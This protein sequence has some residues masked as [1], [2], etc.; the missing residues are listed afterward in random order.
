MIL[1]SFRQTTIAAYCKCES[2]AIEVLP[3]TPSIPVVVQQTGTCRKYLWNLKGCFPL[4]WIPLHPNLLTP[5]QW[6]PNVNSNSFPNH[7]FNFDWMKSA[8]F[9]FEFWVC[10]LALAIITKPKYLYDITFQLSHLCDSSH[11]VFISFI[12]LMLTAISSH[13]FNIFLNHSKLTAY[14]QHLLI[15]RQCH[16]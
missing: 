5:C 9:L 8:H 16:Q 10:M 15:S 6:T 2:C 14:S 4:C 3:S 1:P 13:L 7:C 12:F 11:F